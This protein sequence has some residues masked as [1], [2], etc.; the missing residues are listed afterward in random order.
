[1]AK[2]TKSRKPAKS[3]GAPAKEGFARPPGRR[4]DRQEGKG[5]GKKFFVGR[6]ARPALGRKVAPAVRAAAPA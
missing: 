3:K 2:A 4:P 5:S 6:A 1:M